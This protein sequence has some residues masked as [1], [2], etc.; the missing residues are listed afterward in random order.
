M[1]LKSEWPKQ[2]LVGISTKKQWKKY[3]QCTLTK[4]K[5][6]S[7]AKKLIKTKQNNTTET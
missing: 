3:G 1:S 7:L 5:H 4:M 2:M 6:E